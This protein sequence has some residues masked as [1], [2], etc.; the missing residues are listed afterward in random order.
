MYVCMYLSIEVDV[1]VRG[2]VIVEGLSA[3]QLLID[4]GAFVH[5]PPGSSPGPA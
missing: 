1:P 2:Q 3:V 4:I 5:E